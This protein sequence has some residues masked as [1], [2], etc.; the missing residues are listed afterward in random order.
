VGQPK[1]SRV[2]PRAP[3]KAPAS[4]HPDAAPARMAPSAPTAA[5]PEIPS[6]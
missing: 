5:P 4:I 3:M 6:T 1:T 2:A